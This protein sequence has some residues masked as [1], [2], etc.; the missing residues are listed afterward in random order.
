MKRLLLFL[1]IFTGLISHKAGAEAVPVLLMVRSSEQADSS[2][3]N[4]VQELTSLIYN[5]IVNKRVILW[6]SKSKEIQLTPS[7]LLQIEKNSQVSFKQ[8]ETMFVYELWEAG[9][10]EVV[11]RTLGFSF[12]HRSEKGDVSFGYVD[13]ADVEKTLLSNRINTNANGIYSSTYTT[14]VLNKKYAFNIVQFN[15]QPVKTTGESSD[16]LKT[17]VGSLPFNSSLLGYYPPDKF[18][19]SIIDTFTEGTDSKSIN[20]RALVKSIETFLA[21]NEEEFYNLGGDRILSYLQKNKIRV[22]RVEVN[23]MWRKI[24]GELKIE[25]RSVTIFVNDSALKTLSPEEYTAL[26]I[27]IGERPLQEV[28]DERDFNY[29]I[30]RINSQ[31]I[32]RQD[33]YIYQRALLNADWNRVIGYVLGF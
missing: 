1:F 15:G 29:I 9:K 7:T 26:G 12:T 27:V 8:L 2:G 3:C 18:V 6:D 31:Q 16:I 25:T 24:A 33:S 22:T 20:S 28:L 23:E 14:Y 32:R 13:Y 11:T 17:Y 19:S 5:E 10:K 21:T 4:F 30:T